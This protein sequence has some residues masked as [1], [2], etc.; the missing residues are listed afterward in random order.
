[1][2][3]WDEIPT[4]YKFG[5]VVATA[6]LA[7]FTYHTR[8]VTHA[9]AEQQQSKQQAQ[10]ILLRV[11]NKEAEKRVLIREK[12][13]A[14]ERAKIAEAEKIEQD[15]QTLRDQIKSLCDQVNEC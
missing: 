9:E 11:D 14:M 6:T 5:A 12:A 3:N 13:K 2:I 15:L 1:M 7:M 10:L 4:M 8:F